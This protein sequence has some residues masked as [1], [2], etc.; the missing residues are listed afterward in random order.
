VDGAWKI[1]KQMM[2]F[3]EVVYI[4]TGT[5]G[6]L[7]EYKVQGLLLHGKLMNRMCV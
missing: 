3:E 6:C 4:Y 5:V 1:G 2:M 7:K